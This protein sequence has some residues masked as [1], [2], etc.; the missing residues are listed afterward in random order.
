MLDG[1]CWTFLKTVKIKTDKTE[2]EIFHK[3]YIHV[4][5]WC[6]EI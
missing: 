6:D 3:M 5:R 4:L 2:N 1:C